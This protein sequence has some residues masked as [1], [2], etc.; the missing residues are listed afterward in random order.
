MRYVRLMGDKTPHGAT[1]GRW[2]IS[3]A[4]AVV[5]VLFAFVFAGDGLR[6]KR[7]QLIELEALGEDRSTEYVAWCEK[8]IEVL[9]DHRPPAET[10]R[11]AVES[12]LQNNF[13]G[14][15]SDEFEIGTVPVCPLPTRAQTVR[16]AI[17]FATGKAMMVA[18]VPNSRFIEYLEQVKREM[19]AAGGYV[20]Y[21]L[22]IN[23]QDDWTSKSAHIVDAL[24]HGAKIVEIGAALE[25]KPG[26]TDCY[27]HTVGTRAA[28]CQRPMDILSESNF[29]TREILEPRLMRDLSRTD[30]VVFAYIRL[31][32]PIA[33]QLCWRNHPHQRL[34]I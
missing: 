9:N 5:G 3:A 29:E 1:S 15:V 4:A 22:Q 24:G 12:V 19:N 20:P 32:V 21:Q 31:T 23:H 2:A 17:R 33:R 18:V 11:E 7:D 6:D 13:P 26:R 25:I 8:R 16:E 34:T 10:A 30:L 27:N 14:S 28:Y